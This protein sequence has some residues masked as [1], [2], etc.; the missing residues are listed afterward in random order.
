MPDLFQLLIVQPIFNILT[1]IYS[2][3]PGNDFG[4]AV[5]IFTIIIRFLLYPLVKNQLHQTRQMRKLQPELAKIKARNKGNKQ[6]EAM[7]MMELYKKYGIKPMRSIGILAI[8]LPIFIALYQVIQIFV[9]HRDQVA[10][11]SYNFLEG[12]EP[13]K[14]LIENPDSF[15]PHML[16][17][18]DLSKVAVSGQGIYIPLFIMAIIGALTQYIMTRQTMPKTEGT[19]RFRDI[20]ADA[21]NGKQ[22]DQSEMNSVMM[23]GMA[24]ILPI[25]MFF[26]LIS[27]PGVLALYFT[28]SNLVAVAQQHYL[29]KKDETELEEIAE[30]EVVTK[31]HKKATAKAREKQAREGNVTRIVAKDNGRRKD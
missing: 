26:I 27:I 25:M 31:T 16:G 24:K 4:V 1:V 21:A 23:G 22:A 14:R 9:I 19:R 28:T 13:I 15:N 7:Q 17:I 20:M 3:I 12:L 5:I 8:Q 18:I 11:Y 10:Q 2:L 30:E 29:L 6:A